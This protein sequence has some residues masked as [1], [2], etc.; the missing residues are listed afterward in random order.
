MIKGILSILLGLVLTTSVGAEGSRGGITYFNATF[1]ISPWEVRA[2]RCNVDTFYIN[3]TQFDEPTFM[4]EAECDLTWLRPTQ[5]FVYEGIGDIDFFA[6]GVSSETGCRLVQFE[7]GLDED[8]MRTAD[9]F[10]DCQPVSW[11][12]K[13]LWSLVGGTR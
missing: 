4:A 5:P 10:A 8:N 9:L 12:Q 11:A 2:Y 6:N 13:L 7:A 3:A 1:K